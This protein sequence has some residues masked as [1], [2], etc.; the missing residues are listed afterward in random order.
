MYAKKNI[1]IVF[2]FVCETC[3]GTAPLVPEAARGSRQ[4]PPEG[5]DC[6]FTVM[7]PVPSTAGHN[8]GV[9]QVLNGQLN[10]E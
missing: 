6:P 2:S 9:W 5:Q 4:S 10:G 8:A 1:V 3:E 7:S